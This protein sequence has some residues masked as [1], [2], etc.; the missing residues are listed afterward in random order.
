[1]SK[2]AKLM[3]MKSLHFIEEALF[4]L[5]LHLLAHLL[6]TEL[7]SFEEDLGILAIS[8]KLLHLRPKFFLNFFEGLN[9]VLGNNCD[10]FA[11]A[12]N[13]GCPPNSVDVPLRVAQVIVDH[14]LYERDVNAPSSNISCDQHLHL[15][16][17]EF[18]V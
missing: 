1:M 16:L 6:I 4:L 5:P 17:L 11:L 2:T 8:G 15:S 18:A 3:K 7:Q 12:T 9:I 14:Y 13:P 10:G